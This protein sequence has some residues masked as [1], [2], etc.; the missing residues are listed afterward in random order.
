MLPQIQILKPYPGKAPCLET[1]S[2]PMQLVKMR[3]LGEAL[4]QFNWWLLEKEKFGPCDNGRT[5]STAQK[6]R[7]E[8]RHSSLM[9]WKEPAL[10]THGVWT[11]TLWSWEIINF[12]RTVSVLLKPSETETSETAEE[13]WTKVIVPKN[14]LFLFMLMPLS[15][16]VLLNRVNQKN[17]CS[18]SNVLR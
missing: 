6:W 5:P 16:A 7:P 18:Q 15:R 12:T 2:F 10:L 4:I 11:C 1:G 8:V 3:L 17:W 13:D 9:A 14:E